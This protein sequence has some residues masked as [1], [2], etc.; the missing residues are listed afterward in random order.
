MWT[1]P[2][3]SSIRLPA[4]AQVGSP[5]PEPP[6]PPPE[7]SVSPTA[8][9]TPEPKPSPTATVK[10]VSLTGGDELPESGRDVALHAVAGGGLTLFGAALR[11]IAGKRSSESGA[12]TDHA[13]P[14]D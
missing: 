9:A 14:E 6:P 7:P 5:P 1:V 4:N 8:T 3:V 11:K 12:S 10:G 13:P 2:V